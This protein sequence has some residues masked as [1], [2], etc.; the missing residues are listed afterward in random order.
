MEGG[1][2]VEGFREGERGRREA[3]LYCHRLP[4]PLFLPPA[5]STNGI[6]HTS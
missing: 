1:K 4:P 6:D 5:R 3:G 2:D